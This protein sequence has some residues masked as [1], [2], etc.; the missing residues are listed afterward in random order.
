MMRDYT[1]LS[2]SIVN[3]GL[4]LDG[5][6]LIKIIDWDQEKDRIRFNFCFPVLQQVSLPELPEIQ[7]VSIKP[8]K[9]LKAEYYGNYQTSDR[10]WYALMDYADKN[11][12]SVSKLPVEVFYSNPTIGGDAMQWKAEIYMP[13]QDAP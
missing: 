9:V 10:A 5:P 1:Y 3:S 12:I 8:N 2:N 7:Y 11:N 13:I 6:P 4:Q